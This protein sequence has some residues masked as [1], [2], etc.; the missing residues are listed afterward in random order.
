M[1]SFQPISPKSRKSKAIHTACLGSNVAGTIGRAQGLRVF[2]TNA[3]P[4]NPMKRY[5]SILAVSAAILPALLALQARAQTHQGT[6]EQQRACRPDAVRFCRGIHEDTAI[7]NCLRANAGRLH[8][9][10]RRVIEGH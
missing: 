8:A 9:A 7:A 2:G 4:W 1:Q 5:L 6:P 10:C 3:G